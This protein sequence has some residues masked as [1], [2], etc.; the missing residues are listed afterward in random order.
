MLRRI[1]EGLTRR[2]LS[3]GLGFIIMAYGEGVHPTHPDWLPA[4]RARER[5]R[6]WEEIFG[7]KTIKARGPSGDLAMINLPRAASIF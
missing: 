7:A 4:L 5:S 3:T 1:V 2:Q 6:L